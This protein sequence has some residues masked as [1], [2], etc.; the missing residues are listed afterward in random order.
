[1]NTT[2]LLLPLCNIFNKS[3]QCV[4]S[5]LL[6]V[7]LLLNCKLNITIKKSN[8]KRKT[9]KWKR[10]S[11]SLWMQLISI[12][13][14]SLKRHHTSLLLGQ[15]QPLRLFRLFRLLRLLGLGRPE[16]TPLRSASRLAVLPLP[17][18]P[19]QSGLRAR[20]GL[21][22]RQTPNRHKSQVRPVAILF[23]CGSSE[24]NFWL[25]GSKLSRSY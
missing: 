4:I 13:S 8:R 18:P 11:Q 24:Y 19:R 3:I 14:Q 15:L 16:L 23:R 9:S 21:S 22:R 2:H 17:L 10:T 5:C 25:C 6:F 1:V 7:L 20:S 12:I